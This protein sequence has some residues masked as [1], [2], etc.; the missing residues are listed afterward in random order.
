MLLH[1][2]Y[3]HVKNNLNFHVTFKLVVDYSMMYNI[4]RIHFILKLATTSCSFKFSVVKMVGKIIKQAI[5]QKNKTEKTFNPKLPDK[6][7]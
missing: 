5:F 7:F 6:P 2:T 3:K 4:V 1:T